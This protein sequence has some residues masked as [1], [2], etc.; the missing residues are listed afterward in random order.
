[1]RRTLLTVLAVE[2]ALIGLGLTS[3][4]ETPL[5]PQE[6]AYVMDARGADRIS[7]TNVIQSVSGNAHVMGEPVERTVTFDI[8]KHADGSVDGWYHSSVRGPGGADIK[9]RM[10]CL[11]VVG[12]QAWARGTIVAAV[13]PG[14]IGRPVSMRFID[15]GEGAN[16]PPDEFGGTWANYDCATEPDLSTRQL[17]IGNLQVR[18]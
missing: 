14:N 10:E 3:C 6:A 1:M 11:H 17:K 13:N 4:T 18:G 12:N 8:R 9:V 5:E 2:L 15:N 7:D 16:A